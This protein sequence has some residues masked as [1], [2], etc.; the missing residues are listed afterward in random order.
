MSC[1]QARE[2][3]LSFKAKSLKLSLLPSVYV[4]VWT[5]GRPTGIFGQF[6]QPC[7]SKEATAGGVGW[8]VGLTALEINPRGILKE[9]K[10]EAHSALSAQSLRTTFHGHSP[11]ISP[12]GL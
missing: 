5:P 11:H 8:D 4:G 7:R 2:S 10:A 1:A 3:L 12:L 6:C 9:T